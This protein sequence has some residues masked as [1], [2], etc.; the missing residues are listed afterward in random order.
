MAARD[1]ELHTTSVSKFFPTIG[2]VR[3]TNQII[4]A[5]GSA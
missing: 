4:A 1:A 2:R 3:R 5:L